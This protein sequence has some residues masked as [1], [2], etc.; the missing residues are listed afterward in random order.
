VRAQ[1]RPQLRDAPR[2]QHAYDGGAHPHRRLDHAHER[3]RRR[4][5]SLADLAPDVDASILAIAGV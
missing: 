3:T 2:R 1:L 4:R 5:H